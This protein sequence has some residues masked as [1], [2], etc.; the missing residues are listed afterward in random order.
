MTMALQR[1]RN[2][3]VF[4]AMFLMLDVTEVQMKTMLY[5]SM[6]GSHCVAH[7]SGLTVPTL[8][9]WCIPKSHNNGQDPPLPTSEDSDSF[10]I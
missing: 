7:S 5:Y 1:R 2:G 10:M 3:I 9:V 6:P 8:V 4:Y